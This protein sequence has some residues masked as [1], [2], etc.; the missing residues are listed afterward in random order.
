MRS[1]H[2]YATIIDPTFSS[3]NG[4]EEFDTMTCI[5]CGRVDMTRGPSGQLEVL[6]YRADGTHYLKQAGFCRNCYKEICPACVGKP[7]SN[8]FRRLDEQEAAARKFI[9]A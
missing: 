8:R 3:G 9:C 5:H 6:V 1:P 2:G 7:C 4:V